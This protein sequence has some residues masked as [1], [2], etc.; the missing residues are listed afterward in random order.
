MTRRRPRVLLIHYT[1][2]SILGGVEQVMGA[3]AS[4]L[5]EAGADVTIVAGRGRAPRGAR[6]ARIAEV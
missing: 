2:P 5:R 6:L 3:H 1:A 4:A